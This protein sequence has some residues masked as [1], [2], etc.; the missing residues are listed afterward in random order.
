MSVVV[1]KKEKEKII[2]G[3]DQ[4]V[5]SNNKRRKFKNSKIFVNDKQNF[6]IGMVGQL[7]VL[8]FLVNNLDQEI[9]K[10]VPDFLP[11]N[12]FEV[13]K[14]FTDFYSK[15]IN[16]RMKNNYHCG[17]FIIISNNKI[18][19]HSS[20]WSGEPEDDY[21]AIGSGERYAEIELENDN[22]VKK[23]VL[24]ANKFDLHVS[25]FEEFE[26]LIQKEK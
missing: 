26:I 9:I 6:A 5:G 25:G 21:L 20:F 23:S 8:Q 24:T 2:I 7:E 13:T 12:A 15:F 16:D 22:S 19:K 11:K 14:L 18:F 1:A 4:Y 17:K 10:G 3:S